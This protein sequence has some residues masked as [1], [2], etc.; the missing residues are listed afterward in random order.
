MK[1]FVR[2]EIQHTTCQCYIRTFGFVILSVAKNLVVTAEILRY[3]QND[4]EMQGYQGGDKGMAEKKVQSGQSVNLGGGVRFIASAGMEGTIKEVTAPRKVRTARK[5]RV[6]ESP[7]SEFESALERTGFETRRVFEH[8]AARPAGKRVVRAAQAATFEIETDRGEIPI[9][10]AQEPNGT[11]TWHFPKPAALRAIRGAREV[12]AAQPQK[13]TWRCEVSLPPPRAAAPKGKR[14]VRGMLED[15]GK[16]ILKVLVIKIVD[17]AAEYVLNKVVRAIEAQ[18]IQEGFKL[19]TDTFPD[20]GNPPLND[21]RFLKTGGGNGRLLV[22]V[23]GTF[24]TCRGGFGALEGATLNALRQ[25]YGNRVV[26]FDHWTVSKTPIDN[27]KDFLAALPK[28]PNLPIDVITHSRGGLVA[29]TLTELSDQLPKRN[30]PLDVQRVVFVGT[31][32]AGTP[33]A[34]GQRLPTLINYLTNLVNFLPKAS[35]VIAIDL[36]LAAVKWLAAHVP[37]DLP[38]LQV[39]GPGSAFLSAINAR[40]ILSGATY[41]AVTANYEA[42]DGLLERLKDVG[43]DIVFQDE[44]DLVVPT[45]SVIS[46]DVVT[47]LPPVLADSH[48]FNGPDVHHTSYFEHPD[49]HGFIAKVLN[50]TLD[51]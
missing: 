20:G 23:H 28:T 37:Q 33:L 36:L 4:R 3:T 18:R 26:G 29:R 12:R 14:R 46:V 27:A 35:I 15:I 19:V 45:D 44:N 43:M 39:Q 9:V 50:S 40:S 48:R 41:A 13:V 11:L 32:N 49:T 7:L 10:L 5:V 42:S 1:S 16:R 8:T 21:W 25:Q 47:G 30:P 31:P 17:T 51:I 38:G 6:A 24:S 34:D 22:F 2:G